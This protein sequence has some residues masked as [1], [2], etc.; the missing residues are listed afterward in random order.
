VPINFLVGIMALV[1]VV[2]NLYTR[3]SILEVT[4]RVVD[5]VYWI[6]IFFIIVLC[7]SEYIFSS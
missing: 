6:C 4:I 5:A 7:L 1:F 3:K 2:I